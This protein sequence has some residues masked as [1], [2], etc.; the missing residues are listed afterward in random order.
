[1]VAK[2]RNTLRS[3][4]EAAAASR[5]TAAQALAGSGLEG[6]A[7][8]QDAEATQNPP[9]STFLYQ[10]RE[11]KKSKQLNKQQTFLSK[12]RERSTNSDPALAGVS[13]SA[14]RR[15]KRHMREDLKP[16]MNDLL[17]SLGQEEDLKEHVTAEQQDDDSTKENKRKVTKVVRRE[18][19][20]EIESAFVRRKKNEPNIRNQRG[21]KA[22]TI[23]ETT[24]MVEVLS[25]KSFQSNTFS[26]L[27]D[28]IKMR[29]R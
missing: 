10:P 17:T 5:G 2:K 26:S 12:V 20:P 24:R 3:K 23:K 1:M 22:L 19:L 6:I 15:R 28:V 14:V 18:E 13:K 11:T 21:A 16:K 4:A 27:R 8:G 25:N 9:L 7:G 29:N